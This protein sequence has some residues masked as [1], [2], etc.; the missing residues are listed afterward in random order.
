MAEMNEQTRDA[1]VENNVKV[2]GSSGTVNV[3]GVELYYERYGNGPHAI[4]CVPGALGGTIFFVPQIN[5]FGRSGS[6]YT[7][8]AYDPR[9]YGRSRQHSR[10][11]SSPLCYEIDA[12]DA[13]LLMKALGFKEFSILGWCDGGTCAIIAA[14]KFP[15]VIKY[16]VVWGARSFLE[17]MD[18][19]LFEKS[20]SVDNWDPKIRAMAEIYYGKELPLQLGK[21]VCWIY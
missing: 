7:F 19:E 15:D 12:Q 18:V 21:V 11:Y 9:G 13:I 6:G 4:L 16:M 8:I 5:Y 1:M 20:R 2:K 17:S 3:N 14:A 10:V